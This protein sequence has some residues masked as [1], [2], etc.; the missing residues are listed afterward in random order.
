[1]RA[2]QATADYLTPLTARRKL[3]SLPEVVSSPAFKQLT[4]TFKRVK[5]IARELKDDKP[6][7]LD[8]LATLLREPAE[9]E[10]VKG[11]QLRIP[12]AREA[13][14]KHDYRSAFSELAGLGPAVDRFFVDVLVMADD[15]QVRKARLSV[16]A[17]VR[18]VVLGI[19]DVSELAADQA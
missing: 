19:A 12:K 16:M 14:L 9:A 4:T 13:S 2:V 17:H 8:R 11:L 6:L 10:L 1:V 15:P 18:D 3:E 7:E 5:N